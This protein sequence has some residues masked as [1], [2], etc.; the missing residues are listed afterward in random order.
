[1]GA[2]GTDVARESSSIVLLDDDFTSIVNGVRMGRRIF[3][4]IRKA[5]SYVL[6]VHI[7]IAGITMLAVLLGWPLILLPVHILFLELIIDPACSMVFEA[8]KEEKDV[9]RRPPRNPKEK[10][11]NK[12]T[13]QFSVVQGAIILSMVSL[14]FYFTYSTTKSETEARAISF[15]ALVVLSIFLILINRAGESPIFSHIKEKSTVFWLVSGGSI[16]F[17]AC[18]LTIPLL[19]GI[20]KFGV[21]HADDCIIAGLI[22]ITGVAILETIKFMGRRNNHSSMLQ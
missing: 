11:L 10:I 7:P 22:V 19:R 14:L 4:N 6:A 5:M 13:V 17:L 18:A 16:L 1:M 15:S 12:K 20:F 21:L 3:D 8:C 2:K 9:M